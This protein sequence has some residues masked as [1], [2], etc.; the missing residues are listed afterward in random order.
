MK[1]STVIE[2]E[3]AEIV[4]AVI[5]SVRDAIKTPGGGVTVKFVDA[6][7]K[8]IEKC[9]AYVTYTWANK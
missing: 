1:A 2:L 7:G 9:R 8:E 3:N 5:N 4:T 6:N